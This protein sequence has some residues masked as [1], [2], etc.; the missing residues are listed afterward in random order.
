M[1]M[2]ALRDLLDEWDERAAS[3]EAEGL[4]AGALAPPRGRRGGGAADPAPLWH[5]FLDTTR[6][7]R[8][9]Q[10]L[11]GSR[12]PPPLGRGG[13]RG[14]PGLALHARDDAR[15]AGAR[16]PRP[17]A[18]PGVAAAGRA[19]LE[20]RGD[21]A[22]ARADGRRLPPRAAGPSA[23]GDPLLERARRRLRRP[24]LPRARHPGH[25]PQ[26]RDRP[27]GPRL[28]PR[29][30]ARQRRRGGDGRAARAG[31]ARPGG[32]AAP[33]LRARPRRSAARHGAGAAGRGAGGP[34]PG[35]GAAR[36]RGPPAAAPRR[37]RDRHVHVRQQRPAEG[38]RAHRPRARHEA[39]RARGGAAGGGRGRG[40]AV[41]PA[42]L[43]HVR[44]LPRDDGDA[45][46]GRDLRLRRQ[47]VL[48]HAGAGPALGAAHR[49]SSASRAAGRSCASGASRT[50]RGTRR[51]ARSPGTACA[52]GSPP[53]G[54]STRRCSA[55]S[56]GTASSCA[57]GSG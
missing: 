34:R 28:H 24:R 22:A 8:F 35:P 23:G 12:G 26:P 49:A 1:T 39:L 13:V 27:R 50:A 6:R 53:P 33:R 44:P 18:V 29:P 46:L 36:A 54:T 15:P 17:D 31:R 4:T 52:G 11:P 16:A 7:P 38:R 41:L 14:H 37:A 48:R 40:A 47:P 32:A 57:A 51:C 9:L 2:R 45:V 43:P 30:P 3:P 20:L 25:A 10:S 21:R 42:A 19:P 56:S 55:T 5:R